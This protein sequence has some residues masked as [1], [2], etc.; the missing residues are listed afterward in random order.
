[1]PTLN[2]VQ[3]VN[4]ALKVQMRADERVVLMGE[5][6]G[7]FGGVFRAT[8]GLYEEFGPNRVIDTPLAE[9]GI[10]G[11][12]VGMALYGLRPVPE[13]QFSDFIFPAFDQIVSELAKFRYRSGGMY[14]C[15]MV[16]RTPYGGGIKGG[17]Y[18]SQSPEALF[19]HTPGLKV[20]VPSNPYDAKGL[21]LSAMRQE[22]PVMF[23][24]PKRIYRASKG[25]VPEGD[26]TVPLGKAKIVREGTDISVLAWGAMLHEASEAVEQAAALGISCELIDLRTL[27]PVDIETLVASASRTGRVVVVHEAPRTCGFGAE[28]SA[29]IQERCFVH[30]EAPIARV[31]GWDTPFPYSLEDEYLPRAPRILDQ[32]RKTASYEA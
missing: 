13:I 25:E 22:D 12:A 15:P 14:S 29:L 16:I 1:M 2:L 7:K 32:L 18:H 31:T 10:V 24:E 5:D 19:I 28:L 3:A 6:I 9:G 26:Y 8:L 23:F 27:W 30:L 4:D 21:L 11:T 20:V 17:H